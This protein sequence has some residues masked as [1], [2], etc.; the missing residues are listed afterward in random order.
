MNKKFELLN[1]GYDI[2]VDSERAMLKDKVEMLI[3]ELID[4]IKKYRDVKKEFP[5]NHWYID[6]VNGKVMGLS[7]AINLVKKYFSDIFKEGESH[8]RE[9][10]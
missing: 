10:N 8:G 5:E 2:A 6:Y 9:Q 7:L 4:E 1:L 3:R